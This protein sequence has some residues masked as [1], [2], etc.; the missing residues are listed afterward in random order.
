MSVLQASSISRSYGGVRALDSVDFNVEAGEVTVLI[1]E[2]GAGKS[3]LMRILAGA[4][5]PDGGD[6]SVDGLPVSFSS[7]RD[8]ARAGIGIVFQELNL[9]ANLT[10]AENIFLTRTGAGLLDRRLEREETRRLMRR[11]EQDIDPDAVVGTLTI[12]Q[13]QMVEIAKALA[14]QVRV[15]ILDEPTSSLSTAEVEV[16]FKVIRELR[17]AGVA[18][19]YI[20][21]RLDELMGIGDCVAVLRDGRMQATARVADIS[22]DWIVHQML[23][24]RPQTTSRA[25]RNK[26]GLVALSAENI[27]A[28][29]ALGMK[30]LDG[31]C[32]ECRAGEVTAVYGLLGSG[33]TELLEVLAGARSPCS[34]KV[35]MGGT[36]V[37]RL[38]VAGRLG[39][40]I[41]LVPEDRQ[42]DGVFSNMDVGDNL[43]MSSL[44]A[45]GKAGWINAGRRNQSVSDMLSRLG[46]KASSMAAPIGSLSGGNQQKVLIGRQ[47]MTGPAVLLLDE[48]GR[49]VDVGARAEIF[50]VIRQLADDGL[51]VVFATSDMAEARDVADRILVMAG[52]RIAAELA[53]CEATDAALVAASNPVS[54]R[55]IND[56]GPTAAVTAKAGQS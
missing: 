53:P 18:I 31:V 41:S 12:G 33:R 32:I 1:G 48:P 28:T 24:T 30:V 14:G 6:L 5:A 11:L 4:E 45:L 38:G 16:L 37:T 26:T 23:G 36:D 20:S 50:S 25:A 51:S 27:S 52:G 46:V 8:A 29:G 40:R 55:P 54:A 21:H 47:L 10:V 35:S 56:N 42:R 2:N 13:R 19:I 34:G 17:S 43:V 22:V 7:V 44:S 9:C 3:T 49:G 15:L 39:R